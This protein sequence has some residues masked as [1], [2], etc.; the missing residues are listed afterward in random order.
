MPHC[1]IEYTRNVEAD[2]NIPKLLDIAFEAVASSGHF[3]REA[4]KARAIPFDLYKSGLSRNDYI[5]VK[6]RI[7]SHPVS[8]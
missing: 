3:N 4:I 7:L 6:L 2:I 8:I 5:H 1:I